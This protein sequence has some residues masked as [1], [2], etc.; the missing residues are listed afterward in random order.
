MSEDDGAD[1]APAHHA[2]ED[3]EDVPDDPATAVPSG[4]AVAV[5]SASPGRSRA[6]AGR[7]AE[8]VLRVLPLGTGLV[9]VGLGLGLAFVGL[10]LRRG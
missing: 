4:E 6:G 2:E 1:E 9:L 3:A 8:P 10:R 7:A 5:P